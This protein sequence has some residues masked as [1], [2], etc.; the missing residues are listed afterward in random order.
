MGFKLLGFLSTK[1]VLK[2]VDFEKSYHF[3]ATSLLNSF[4][5]SRRCWQTIHILRH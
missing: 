5:V 3:G 1:W 4:E 2:H